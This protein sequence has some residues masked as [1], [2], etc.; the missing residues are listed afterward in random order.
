MKKLVSLGVVLVLLS[1]LVSACGSA[2]TPQAAAACPTCPAP[3]AEGPAMDL[4]G[5]EVRIAE[6]N[7]YPPFNYL[8]ANSEPIGFDYDLWREVCKRLN[9]TPVFVETAWEGIF[10]AMAAGEFDIGEGGTTFT[11]PRALKVSYTIPYVEYGQVV[12]VLVDDT[13]L[14]DEAALVDS[15]AV[16]GVQLGTTNE[17]TAVKLLGELRVK[18]F[19]SYDLPVVALLS[20]DVNAVIIDEVAAIGFMGQN[21][22]KLKNAFSITS[23]ELLAFPFPPNSELVVPVNMTLQEMFRDGTMD[24]ICE[25][26]LLRP[27]TPSE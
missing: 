19:D 6:E 26:W 16:V 27:C 2:S 4:G 8:D 22:G 3:Q 1:L 24:Q 5:K 11:F 25:K 9:C 17:A 10:E 20:G 7:A 14:T 21:P 18:S 23:G 12:M 13:T 15:D